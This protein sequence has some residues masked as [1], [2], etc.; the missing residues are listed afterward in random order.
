MLLSEICIYI[1]V[2]SI[3]SGVIFNIAG[4][5]AILGIF[6][7]T[8]LVRRKCTVNRKIVISVSIFS[9][10]FLLKCIGTDIKINGSYHG[11]W[12]QYIRIIELVVMLPMVNSI[13]CDI[14]LNKNRIIKNCINLFNLFYYFTI[15][16]TIIMLF[17]NG[18]GYYRVYAITNP[19]YAPQFF[20]IYSIALAVI[21]TSKILKQKE[22]RKFNVFKLVIN[23]CF[24]FAMNYTTQMLFFLIAIF[25]VIIAEKIVGLQNKIFVFISLFVISLIIV[26]IL[27]DIILCINER[28]FEGNK[29]ISMRLVE[30]SNFIKSGDLSGKALGGRIQVMLTSWNTFLAHPLFGVPF[31]SYNY[32]QMT[33]IG[34]HHEWIDDLAKFGLIGGLLFMLMLYKGF[35]NLTLIDGK[36]RKESLCLLRIFILYGFFNPIINMTIIIVAMINRYA[37]KDMS[38]NL[39]NKNRNQR[40]EKENNGYYKKNLEGLYKTL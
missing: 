3:S 26:P 18:K 17:I 8:C 33:K 38:V 9:L 2:I 35:K 30:I 4:E 24:V 29:D 6:V 10:F 13:I 27:P 16:I 5:K 19:V 22:N 36:P 12:A 28:Y 31:S 25:T 37:M 21:L 1:W 39:E 23:G 11:L 15:L 14:E 40:M 7:I 32:D 20:L 34:G